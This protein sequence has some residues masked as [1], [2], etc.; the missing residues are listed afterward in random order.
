MGLFF[1]GNILWF[2]WFNYDFRHVYLI[3]Y[4]HVG[5]ISALLSCVSLKEAPPAP[6]C[7]DRGWLLEDVCACVHAAGSRSCA[8]PC[9][10]FVSLH[11]S[12]REGQGN[13]GKRYHYVVFPLTCKSLIRTVLCKWVYVFFS[14]ITS[15]THNLPARYYL[16]QSY[17]H[18]KPSVS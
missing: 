18:D 5:R 12:F 6:K 9:T 15:P 13:E 17:F 4:I 2:T 10:S 11:F 8:R 3:W 1:R 7:K 14:C 16:L